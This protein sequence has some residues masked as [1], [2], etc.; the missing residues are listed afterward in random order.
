M[1]I[2]KKIIISISYF[3]MGGLTIIAMFPRLVVDEALLIF[4][5]ALSNLMIV[6]FMLI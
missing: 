1:A 5:Y 6:L 2:S 3:L 4:C